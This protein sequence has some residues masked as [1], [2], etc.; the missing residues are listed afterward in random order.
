MFTYLSSRAIHKE[1]L[2]DLTTD[3]FLN[4]L[5]CFIALRGAARQIRSDQGTNFLGAKNKLEKCLKDLDKDRIATY[6]KKAV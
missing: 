4:A 1:M 3:A 5:R 2:E 6:L